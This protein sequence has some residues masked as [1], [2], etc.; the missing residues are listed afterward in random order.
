M[1]LHNNTVCIN[2]DVDIATT[3]TIRVENGATIHATNVNQMRMAFGMVGLL[4][5]CAYVIMLANAKFISEGGVASVYIAN[6]VPGLLVQI[7]APYWFVL[8]SYHTRLRLASVAMAFAFLLVSYFSYRSGTYSKEI[9]LMGQLLGVALISFQCGIGE[10]SL[11]AL[12]GKWDSSSD[13]SSSVRDR[14]S[15]V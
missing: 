3:T 13:H 6:I 7:T 8:V 15:V 4:N 12:A 2:D 11:L 9:V 5:N 10:A 14:K 1:M